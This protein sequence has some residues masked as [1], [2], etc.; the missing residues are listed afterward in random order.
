MVYRSGGGWGLPY[1][2]GNCG[3]PRIFVIY[4][5]NRHRIH[6]NLRRERKSWVME[7]GIG[8]RKRD[9][10][11]AAI[12]DCHSQRRTVLF[13]WLSIHGGSVSLTLVVSVGA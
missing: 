6:F 12:I 7:F 3:F 13:V 11:T 8:P 4:R 5:A 2:G 9:T 1:P 10:K